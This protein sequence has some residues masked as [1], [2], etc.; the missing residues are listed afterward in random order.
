[1]GNPRAVIFD[2]DGV[3]VDSEP[4]HEWAI[5]ESVRDRGWTFTTEQ[6]VRHIVG[7]GDENAYRRISE[8]NGAEMDDAAI[9]AVLVRKW[10]LMGDGIRDGRFAVQPG[11]VDAVRNAAARAP[12]GLCSGSVRSTVVPMLERI[13]LLDAF[14]VVV[15]GDDVHAMKP[16]PA[17]YLKAAGVL[18]VEPAR[19]TAIEDTPTG[20]RAA[21]NAGMRVI[22]VQHTVPAD[23]LHEAD[24]VVASIADLRLG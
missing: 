24:E 6:F 5:R 22:A 10:S 4:L 1:M 8:W 7:K 3:L 23:M 14:G 18:G 13:G 12:I 17:G 15:C 20:V 16:D 19:C 9:R 11:A 21:K 2:F